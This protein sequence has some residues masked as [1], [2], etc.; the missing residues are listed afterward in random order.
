MIAAPVFAAIDSNL[1]LFLV[2]NI[3]ISWSNIAD[4]ERILAA[5][6]AMVDRSV[7]AAKAKGLDHPYLYQNYAALQQDVFPSYGKENLAKLR[8]TRQK[9]D[10]TGV[11][12]KLQPGYFKLG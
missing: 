1:L 4:D 11:W 8:A 3:D 5:A 9:Y 7:A 2:V 6:K 10:P 12:Q